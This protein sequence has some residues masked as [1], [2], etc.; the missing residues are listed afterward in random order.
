M[1]AGVPPKLLR[2]DVGGGYEV[3]WSHTGG[4]YDVWKVNSEGNFVSKI[5]AKLWE[6]EVK[7]NVDL[8]GDGHIGLQPVE[9]NW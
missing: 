1:P 9:A 3:L 7:F 8:N 4:K 2:A 5:K 6:D